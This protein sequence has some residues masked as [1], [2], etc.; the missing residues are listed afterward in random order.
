MSKAVRP[1]PAALS[2]NT[3]MNN[4][5]ESAMKNTPDKP[6]KMSRASY[7]LG[8]DLEQLRSHKDAAG[9]A[10]DLEPHSNA[11]AEMLRDGIPAATI[12]KIVCAR[13]GISRHVAARAIQI[14]LNGADVEFKLPRGHRPKKTEL[15]GDLSS[16]HAAKDTAAEEKA[17][18]FGGAQAG[19]KKGGEPPAPPAAPARPSPAAAPTP[20]RPAAPAAGSSQPVPFPEIP[21]GELTHT[22]RA[23]LAKSWI[24]AQFGDK[25]PTH[26][27]PEELTA[28][29]QA[30]LETL[31]DK[32]APVNNKT[33]QPYAFK[34][35]TPD[36][37]L[38]YDNPWFPPEAVR[39][40]NPRDEN[41][42]LSVHD[43]E[44][45]AL[46][47]KHGYG[48]RASHREGSRLICLTDAKGEQISAEFS[49][50]DL[51]CL[52]RQVRESVVFD[53]ECAR[54]GVST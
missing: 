42:Y 24:A 51:P 3:N 37:R 15:G 26:V 12:L 43:A 23:E 22:E 20:T 31:W 53:A 44:V 25:H 6:Q 54:N 38:T 14:C 50:D 27:K 9:A 34:K 17:P 10:L 16:L 2:H 5:H 13:L 28:D 8:I 1:F 39:M 18:A 29:A 45:R 33:G 48:L 46:M 19:A 30:W 35:L 4:A 21:R 52:G 47:K 11:I 49:R 40:V 7:L 41:D 36:G 32:P